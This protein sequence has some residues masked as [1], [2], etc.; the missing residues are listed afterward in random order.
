MPNFEIDNLKIEPH[1]FVDSCSRR[2]RQE[3]IDYLVDN[4]YIIEDQRDI[5]KSNNGVRNP[6]VNDLR[7]QESLLVL[8]KSRHLLSLDDEETINKLSEKFKYLY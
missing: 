5:K 4:S 2:E 8:S 6:N 1:K 3:L 7:F